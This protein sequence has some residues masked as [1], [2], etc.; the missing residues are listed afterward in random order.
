MPEINYD[1]SGRDYTATL[2]WLYSLLRK[3]LPEYTDFNHSDAG[4]SLIRLVAQALD[5]VNFY[6]DEVFAEGFKNTA[7]FKQSLIDLAKLVD[8]LPKLAC[9]AS[10]VLTVSRGPNSYYNDRI[11]S[12]PKG[13][14]FYRSDSLPYVCLQDYQIPIGIQQIEVESFQGT[15]V[16]RKLLRE[17][18]DYIDLGGKL[19][20]NLGKNVAARTISLVHG[21]DNQVWTEVDSFYRS[22]SNSY[23]YRLEVYADEYQGV[24]DTVFLVLG[25]GNK[26]S[27][28]PGEEMTISYVQTDGPEGNTGVNTISIPEVEMMDMIEVTNPQVASGGAF[29]EGIED[30]R[31]RI[32][33]TVSIQRRGVTK[34]DYGHL[35]K[36]IAGVGDCQAVDRSQERLLPWEYVCV[37]VTTTDG[38]NLSPELLRAVH[39][40]L[41]ERGSLGD[42]DRRYIL[43]DAVPIAIDIECR[44]G[45]YSGYSPDTV[46]NNLNVALQD[47]F[48]VKY[49]SIGSFFDFGS[50][51]VAAGRVP[52]VRWVEFDTPRADIKMGEGEYPAF[53]NINI[54]VVE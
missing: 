38:E 2:E 30:F 19:K 39:R 7:R 17:D 42:W 5:Q 20:C 18:F 31:S 15:Y 33:D 13:T 35:V 11:L 28:F 37:Y 45:I 32:A 53:G 10:T 16:L 40:L 36:T 24:T 54:R 9:A 27:S 3:D 52:G 26:G 12:I 29:T 1:Y 48:A 25:D 23:H 4:I 51:N 21:E 22:F 6:A 14:A 43:K 49:G 44:I 8:V 34:T 50:L 47:T 41:K 46:V